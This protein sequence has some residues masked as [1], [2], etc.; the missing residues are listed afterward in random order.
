MFFLLVISIIYFQSPLSKIKDIHVSGN[1]FIPTSDIV[2]A[3]NLTDKTV[4]FNLQ[5]DDIKERILTLPEVKNVE[6][7]IKFPNDV[8]IHIEEY[9][10]LGY[11]MQEG[12]LKPLLET[13]TVNNYLNGAM[14]PIG[15]VLTNFNDKAILNVLVKQL[16]TMDEEIRNSISEIIYTPKETDKYSVIAFMN[17]GYEVHGTLRTFAE[18]MR[19]Y[20]ALV[21]QLT[22]ENKG[23]IDLEVGLFF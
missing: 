6:V 22:P 2:E 17:D 10:Q 9:R 12:T 18:K 7:S 5:K 16:K 15:P 8:S 14:N 11:I 3:S 20:P 19:Y 23:I 13:G 4:I 1:S 21:K